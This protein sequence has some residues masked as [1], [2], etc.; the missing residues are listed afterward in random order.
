MLMKKEIVVDI[1]IILV[2]II[3]FN[4][5]IF[6]SSYDYIIEYAVLLPIIIYI[7]LVI[8]QLI[9]EQ[10]NHKNEF[11]KRINLFLSF[12]IPV[13]VTFGEILTP[14]K[15]VNL[16]PMLYY[17]ILSA[18]LI[19]N[20][21]LIMSRIDN[22][23]VIVLT[24]P[25]LIVVLGAKF[26]I[27]LIDLFFPP[28]LQEL[29]PYVEV[30][31]TMILS[32]SQI[33]SSPE[34]LETEAAIEALGSVS[35]Q[36]DQI[37]EGYALRKGIG[38]GID[39]GLTAIVFLGMGVLS[40]MTDEWGI[41]PQLVA[42]LFASL[43]LALSTFAGLFGPFYGLA[44]SCK[45]FNLSHGNYRGAVI[46][47]AIEELFAIPFMA[48]SA[49]F[50]LLDLPPIDADTLEDFKSEMQEQITELGD[51]LNALLGKDTAAIPRKTRK[52]IT[53]L[54][55]ET[56]Q[57]ISKLD[58]RKIRQET[59]REFALTYYQYEFSWRPWKRKSAVKEFADIYNI[60]LEDAENALRLIGYKIIEGV[61]TEDMVIN[62]MVSS[63]LK[64]VIMM[65]QKYQELFEDAE[66]GQTA[67]GLAFGA[68]QFLKDH[69]VIRSRPKRIL[70]A[71]RNMLLTIFSIPI[72]L[73]IHFHEYSNR[74]FDVLSDE[75]AD[76]IFLGRSKEL[77]KFRYNEIY[78]EISKMPEKINLSIS[79]LKNREHT[80]KKDKVPFSWKLKRFIKKLFSMIWEVAVFPFTLLFGL[81]K[82]IWKKLH[83][84]QRD[85]RELFEEAVSHKALVSMYQN[86]YEKLVM[87]TDIGY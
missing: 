35:G 68:R 78:T 24:I 57:S 37:A 16:I 79:K 61:M 41:P 73:I 30:T 9:L 22:S 67:T 14:S 56:E 45:K 6:S 86:L 48:A 77:V 20:L 27:F 76:S 10:K 7:F 43:G 59:T 69:Y 62:I 46:Y 1:L 72:V 47:K 23:V 63:A 12:F 33:L 13:M 50:L 25:I 74:I 75:I 19:L 58:F 64:G 44:A 2:N 66:L 85:A 54:L 31:R 81:L 87:Q 3:I 18:F 40:I 38:Q 52:M 49:G 4:L 39:L 65:E 26:L 70:Y 5:I 11:I 51:N 53:N 21:F 28:K 55:N 84:Q 60:S 17:F 42:A 8:L 83:T 15:F 71:L 34:R 29:V 82:W 36:V 80:D 32:V